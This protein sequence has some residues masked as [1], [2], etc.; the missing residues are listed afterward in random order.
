MIR[1]E[2]EYQQTLRR[3]A[4]QEKLLKQQSDELTQSGLPKEQIKRVL[5]PVRCFRQQLQ[6][7]VDSYERLQRGEFDDVTNFSN[8]GRLLIALRIS[9]GITQRELAERLEPSRASRGAQLELLGLGRA[10]GL[11]GR[12]LVVRVHADLSAPRWAPRR[13]AG[14]RPRAAAA[15]GRGCC[16]STRPPTAVNTWTWRCCPSS[17]PMVNCLVSLSAATTNRSRYLVALPPNICSCVSA[18]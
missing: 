13:R 2:N 11:V 15:P 3:L 16:T 1:N 5:D 18:R 8:L 14:A 17:T 9:Q 7:E 10:L 6:D 12:A 4:E